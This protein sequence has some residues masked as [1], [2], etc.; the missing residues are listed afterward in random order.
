MIIPIDEDD[1]M[2]A[3]AGVAFGNNDDGAGEENT[4]CCADA[5]GID[6]NPKE[7]NEEVCIGILDDDDNDDD[8][9]GRY[10]DDPVPKLA[11]E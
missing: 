11:P 2:E 6:G 10:I 7:D 5:I 3:A 8:D 1:D 9:D 4:L